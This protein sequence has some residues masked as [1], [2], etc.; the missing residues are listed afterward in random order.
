[1]A[2]HH[3]KRKR[4]SR[5]GWGGGG[6]HA[7]HYVVSGSRCRTAAQLGNDYVRGGQGEDKN[8]QAKTAGATC[9]CSMRCRGR[10][11]PR[12]PLTLAA[13]SKRATTSSTARSPMACTATCIETHG[14]DAD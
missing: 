14:E 7:L 6:A 12:L 1:M 9:T 10:F 4:W 2:A 11:P 8:R 5:E 3:R 13:A